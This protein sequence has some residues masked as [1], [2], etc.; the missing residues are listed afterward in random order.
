M[1]VG[2]REL[3]GWLVALFG[4]TNITQ[5]LLGFTV[6][7][8]F[9]SRGNTFAAL[10]HWLLGYFGMFFI[11]VHGWDGTGYQH[12]FSPTREALT[13]WTWTTAREWL[14]SDVALTL[15]VMGVV[16]I[17]WLVGLSVTW[18]KA[19]K[20]APSRA[21]LAAA[22]LTLLVGGVP[23]FAVVSS[24]LV[25]SLGW[26][27]GGLATAALMAALS[28]RRFGPLRLLHRWFGFEERSPSPSF[29]EV[30]A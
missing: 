22:I 11:L 19:S 28:H 26:A 6:A 14:T 1:H 20:R 25:R 30:T 3:P 7:R 17:P 24:L 23:A 16:L 13:G 15:M 12:F 10:A 9:S 29:V 21:S 8:W 2:T 4:V 5:G 27:G 18:L